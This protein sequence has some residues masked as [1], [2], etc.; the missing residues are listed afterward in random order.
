MSELNHRNPEQDQPSTVVPKFK[1]YWIFNQ[2][3]IKYSTK[4]AKRTTK[5]TLKTADLLTTFF[6]TVLFSC[7]F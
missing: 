2:F 1:N 5:I 4:R 6:L 7:T 3:Y